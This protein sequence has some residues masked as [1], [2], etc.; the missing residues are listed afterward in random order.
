MKDAVQFKIPFWLIFRH[1]CGRNWKRQGSKGAYRFH[2][3][4]VQHQ[5]SNKF[6]LL[7]DGIRVYTRLL[8][9][10]AIAVLFIAGYCGPVNPRLVAR[11]P[12]IVHDIILP[13][14]VLG[15]AVNV[16]LVPPFR[17]W[18]GLVAPVALI[19]KV[20]TPLAATVAVKYLVLAS[21]SIDVK[22]ALFAARK[23]LLRL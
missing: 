13:A 23:V 22:V 18:S 11:D 19:T 4:R 12:P 2:G 8:I 6:R 16:P 17:A 1:P 3:D 20:T 5:L 14:L 21:A 10:N 7:E 9:R 15:V